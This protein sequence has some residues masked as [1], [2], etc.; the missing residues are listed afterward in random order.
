MKSGPKPAA[1]SFRDFSG[2]LVH[3]HIFSFP[4]SRLEREKNPFLYSNQ[5][6][7]AAMAAVCLY[8]NPSTRSLV[9][10]LIIPG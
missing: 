5:C 6:K 3:G 9:I 1:P 2:W 8:S 10:V 4:G 7:M